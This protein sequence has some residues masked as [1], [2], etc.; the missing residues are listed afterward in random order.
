MSVRS[1]IFAA[2]LLAAAWPAVALAAETATAPAAAP[3][4]KP[5]TPP[6]A[7]P[8]AKPAAAPALSAADTAKL[9]TAVTKK[10]SELIA[11]ANAAIA[12]EKWQ[13]ATDI[14]DK[15]IVL[16][17]RWNYFQSLGNAHLNLGHFDKALVAYNAGIA[18]AT[19]DTATP[20]QQTIAARAQMLTSKGV[21]LMTLT[22]TK[23]AIVAFA[24]AAA[25]SPTPAI[26]YFK[27]CFTQYNAED[28]KGAAASCA[29]VV[30]AD[31]A[32]AD[33][34]FLQGASLYATAA[35][36]KVAAPAGTAEA[37]KKYLELS[38]N[39]PLVGAAQNMLATLQKPVK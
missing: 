36:E 26:A 22:R 27:L 6:A 7:K 3:A 28:Y 34:Y 21:A 14:L 20:A 33:A 18:G 24:D 5:A 19:A 23:E 29:K 8:A 38:P 37:L 16:M 17:P 39:G 32:K 10:E 13:E 15:L 2:A 30:K 1:S 11:K 12:A 9:R 31:P 25:I 35:A 4:T